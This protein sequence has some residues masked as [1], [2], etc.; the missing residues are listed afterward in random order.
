MKC[1]CGCQYE[2]QHIR[3]R[4]EARKSPHGGTEILAEAH[5][6]LC[7]GGQESR[8][9]CFRCLRTCRRP[10]SPYM[11]GLMERPYCGKNPVN[12]GF[13]VAWHN[14]WP[15]IWW[16]LWSAL[17]DLCG[18]LGESLADTRTHIPQTG[19]EHH[20]RMGSPIPQRRASM[21]RKLWADLWGTVPRHCLTISSPSPAIPAAP[22]ESLAWCLLGSSP[23]YWVRR[24]RDSREARITSPRQVPRGFQMVT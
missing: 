20:E 18:R 11:G 6:D 13:L 12:T 23:R 19:A 14:I 15:D 3:R 16:R 5:R 2:P 9:E 22:C 1:S 10:P 17:L 24:Y 21:R 7:R 8:R 4:R